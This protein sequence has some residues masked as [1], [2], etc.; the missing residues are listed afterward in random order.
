MAWF[1]SRR[2]REGPKKVLRV[3]LIAPVQSLDP[4]KTQDFGS[5][6]VLAQ[7]YQ[8]PFSPQPGDQP[9]APLL[10][11]EPLRVEPGGRLCSAAVRSDVR[12]SDGTPLTARHVAES[13]ASTDVVR[14][15][16]EVEAREERVVFHLR[17]PDARFDLTLS[18]SYC[19]VILER[20]G[21]LLGTGPFMVAEPESPEVMRLVRNPHFERRVALD[22]LRF[23]VYPASIEEGAAALVRA[24]EAGEVDFT[25]FLSREEVGRISGARKWF[26][27][28]NSTAVLYFN[29][30]NPFLARADTRRALAQAI[31]RLE[32]TR[33]CYSNALAFVASSLLPPMMGSFTDGQAAGAEHRRELP[34]DAGAPA[35]RLRMLLVW[36]PRPYLPNPR[37]A[38]LVIAQ[39]VGELGVE[40]EIVPTGSPREYS[41]RVTRGDYDLLLSGWIADTADPVDFLEA[42]LSSESIPAPGASPVNRAN[43][44]RW[45]SREMDEALRQYRQDRS[46]LPRQRILELL[47]EEVP[48]LP[49]MYGPAVVVHS[50]KVIGFEPSPL[51]LADFSRVDLESS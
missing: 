45:R 2:K 14:R 31:D 22:E 3:G 18:Q 16:A 34:A 44:S 41:E 35:E 17:R 10:F 47:R 27:P 46:D 24:V 6:L 29:A 8:Q 5:V 42:N 9:P 49:L 36:G 25:S 40:L 30:E 38:A 39:G 12:F 37:R 11:S 32:V 50:W 4:R 28:G 48:L 21:Q 7:V 33:T 51:G 43:R 26:L 15:V 1:G 20:D 13:L 23:S 19:A